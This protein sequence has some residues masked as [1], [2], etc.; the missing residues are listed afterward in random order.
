MVPGPFRFYILRLDLT[1]PQHFTKMDS[2]LKLSL[3]PFKSFEI[4]FML[5]H[6]TKFS[7]ENDVR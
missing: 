5:P 3:S 6:N 1:S 7:Q 2:F 4:A